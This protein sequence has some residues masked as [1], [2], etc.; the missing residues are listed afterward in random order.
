MDQIKYQTYVIREFKNGFGCHAERSVGIMINNPEQNSRF[1]LYVDHSD[2][3]VQC[4]IAF[5]TTN[6]H[7]NLILLGTLKYSGIFM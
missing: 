2:K 4:F 3:I 5:Y 6:I 1:L 7:E